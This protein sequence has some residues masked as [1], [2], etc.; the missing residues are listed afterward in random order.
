MDYV[1]HKNRQ[2]ED[3]RVGY[4]WECCNCGAVH[5]SLLY[6]ACNYCKHKRYSCCRLNWPPEKHWPSSTTDSKDIS[7][8]GPSL[9]STALK[10]DLQYAERPWTDGFILSSSTQSPFKTL[11]RL[12]DL[13]ILIEKYEHLAVPDT[14]TSIN[15][16][17]YAA[18][19]RLNS[20]EVIALEDDSAK[21]ESYRLGDGRT[22][23]AIG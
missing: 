10:R 8:Q 5:N 7:V 20:R 15:A 6:V 13:P 21:P 9:T 17:S 14:G 12:L 4:L 23:D 11:G 1:S 16:I 3:P 19:S 2:R 22:I 18:L